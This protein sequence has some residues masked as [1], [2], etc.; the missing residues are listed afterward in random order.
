MLRLPVGKASAG[1]RCGAADCGRP[2]Q[3]FRACR[4]QNP[5]CHEAPR[6]RPSRL[7]AS[8]TVTRA[9][10]CRWDFTPRSFRQRRVSPARYESGAIRIAGALFSPGEVCTL[11][12][13]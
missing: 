3:R 10:T 6:T 2:P 9:F 8:R 11:T 1:P 5:K 4:V 13:G 7:A 12:S